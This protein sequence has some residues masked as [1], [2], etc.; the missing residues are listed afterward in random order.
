MKIKKEKLLYP[1]N[2]KNITL[3]EL[4][5]FSNLDDKTTSSGTERRPGLTKPLGDLGRAIRRN[6]LQHII[7]P[8]F[9]ALA[10][11][12]QY[13]FS[14]NMFGKKTVI[15]MRKQAEKDSLTLL[16]A[17]KKVPPNQIYNIVNQ[18]LEDYFQRGKYASKTKIGRDRYYMTQLTIDTLNKVFNVS[19]HYNK[20]FNSIMTLMYQKLPP[21]SLA[22]LKDIIR[23]NDNQIFTYMHNLIADHINRNL[24]TMY[25]ISPDSPPPNDYVTT[26]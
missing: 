10:S 16:N 7:Q 12:L 4:L 3:N 13:D 17:L 9:P 25:I 19:Q 6:V 15:E 1:L 26:V 2:K 22:A 20:N 21:Q 11:I 14:E 24:R 23:E 5:G 8:F 18:L